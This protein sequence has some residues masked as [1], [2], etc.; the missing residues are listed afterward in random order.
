MLNVYKYFLKKQG[1]IIDFVTDY[2][3]IV[4]HVNAFSEIGLHM[5]LNCQNII[6]A[7]NY[8]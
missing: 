4:T 7:E 5:I 8:R 1:L 3:I 2:M 6:L